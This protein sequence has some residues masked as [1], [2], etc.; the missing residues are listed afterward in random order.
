[1]GYVRDLERPE[2]VEFFLIS[3]PTK[4]T[5]IKTA[6]FWHKDRINETELRSQK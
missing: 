4:T 5:V 1:M 3:K 6:Y 2:Y